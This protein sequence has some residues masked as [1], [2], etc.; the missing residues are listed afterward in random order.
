MTDLLKK[1]IE[2]ISHLSP[3]EKKWEAKFAGSEKELEY[4]AGNALKEHSEGKTE[5]YF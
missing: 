2:E 1:A 3:I 5:L 4:L